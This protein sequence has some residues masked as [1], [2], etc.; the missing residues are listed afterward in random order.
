MKVCLL[1][2]QPPLTF[3]TLDYYSCPDEDTKRSN[4]QPEW[5]VER[6]EFA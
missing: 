1:N 5:N 3:G 2:R 6:D 4:D